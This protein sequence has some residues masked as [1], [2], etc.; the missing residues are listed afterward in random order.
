MA[1]IEDVLERSSAD[2][3]FR[4]QL[5]SDPATA[6]SGYVLYDEDLD[7]LAAHLN[8]GPEEGD[9]AGPASSGSALRAALTDE[10]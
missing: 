2:P 7:T 9:D 5:R 4:Q 3:G 6:L 8:T 1:G 10:G